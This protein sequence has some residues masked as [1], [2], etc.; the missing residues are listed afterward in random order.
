[1]IYSYFPISFHDIFPLVSP[2][3]RSKAPWIFATFSPH[4][5]VEEEDGVAALVSVDRKQRKREKMR[6]SFMFN[7]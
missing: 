2:S 7:I 3:F 1:M 6:V 4:L 5:A